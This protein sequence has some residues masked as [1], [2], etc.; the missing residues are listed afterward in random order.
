LVEALTLVFIFD[1]LL[2]VR[3]GIYKRKAYIALP[4]SFIAFL[5]AIV[6]SWGATQDSRM[7]AL[8]LLYAVAGVVW[9]FIFQV[10]SGTKV[11]LWFW[12][13]ITILTTASVF[14]SF[15]YGHVR[16][17][18]G[19]GEPSHAKL[20]LMKEAPLTL[21][22]VL[23]VKVDE[24]RPVVILGETASELM[25][26]PADAATDSRQALRVKR[27]LIAGIISVKDDDEADFHGG[28]SKKTTPK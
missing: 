11:F 21:K 19:G 25:V 10:R 20:I 27:A 9:N 7:V 5:G 18:I 24:T 4:L 22:S 13:S 12:A 26:I 15:V 14:G 23:G 6:G 28:E 17:S 2:L 3:P 16:R 8:F 1:F